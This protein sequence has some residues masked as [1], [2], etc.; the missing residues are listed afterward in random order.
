MV[1]Y[2]G[3]FTFGKMFSGPMQLQSI[4]VVFL[5]LGIDIRMKKQGGK[6]WNNYN[7]QL[8]EL[9]NWFKEPL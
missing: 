3:S 9:T 4:M 1:Q 2:A 6:E 7:L 5:H 8:T